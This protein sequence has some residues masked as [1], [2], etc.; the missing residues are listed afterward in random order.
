MKIKSTMI[1][2]MILNIPLG[3][4][5]LILRLL[6]KKKPKNKK[7]MFLFALTSTHQILIIHK[8]FQLFRRGH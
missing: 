1:L 7:I 6:K 8:W 4:V 5:I 2:P 3:D